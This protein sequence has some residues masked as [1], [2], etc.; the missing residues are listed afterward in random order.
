ML[1]RRPDKTRSVFHLFLTQN[2]HGKPK[3]QVVF[4]VQDFQRDECIVHYIHNGLKFFLKFQFNSYHD[5]FKKMWCLENMLCILKEGKN[6]NGNFITTL[7]P[8][9]SIYLSHRFR[10]KKNEQGR[11]YLEH[12]LL[13]RNILCII[14]NSYLIKIQNLTA[15]NILRHTQKSLVR[16]NHW[17][18]LGRLN[19]N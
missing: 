18:K 10:R 11:K 4:E 6:W 5:C 12:S 17:G 13:S 2:F 8:L 14:R 19:W 16:I 3:V 1:Q 15:S 9:L 7:T